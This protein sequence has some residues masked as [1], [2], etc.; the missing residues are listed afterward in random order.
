M[1]E[2][3]HTTSSRERSVKR[4]VVS[5][6]P[7]VSSWLLNTAKGR[8]TTDGDEA[9]LFES[10]EFGFSNPESLQRTMWWFM[11]LHFGLINRDK[12]RKLCWGDVELQLDEDGRELL[13]WLSERGTKNRKGQ[14]IGHGRAV[15]PKVYATGT[16]R[17]P[18]MMY[19]MFKSHR[20]GEM[21]S[22]D[23][24]FFLALRHN[25]KLDSHIWYK[26]A[27]LGKN[28]IGKFMQQAAGRSGLAQRI[29]GKVSNHSVRKTS[30]SRLLD[31][32]REHCATNIVPS[33][34]F[35]AQLSGHKNTQSLQSCKSANEQHQ[36]QM[37]NILSR[38]QQPS[39]KSLPAPS[40]GPSSHASGQ[41]IA[42]RS[43][44]VQDRGQLMSM[45]SM[46]SF[47]MNTLP[48]AL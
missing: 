26:K 24:P 34:N 39:N 10:G 28:E 5:W 48:S 41:F 21:N 35:P 19:K 44:T 7:Q 40:Q 29:G 32:N 13:V 11:S 36:W 25:R 20:P 30:I 17:C 38:T 31:A 9:K 47:S 6:L 4:P 3:E 27:P 16:N 2:S 14:E 37:S 1:S 43:A 33:E 46:H 18:I 15:Q 23:S 42:N 8:L 12:S 22:Q 45:Q